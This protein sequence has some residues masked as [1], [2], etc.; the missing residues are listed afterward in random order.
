MQANS[1]LIKVVA[2]T[3]VQTTSTLEQIPQAAKNWLF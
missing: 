2:E 3:W 1:A